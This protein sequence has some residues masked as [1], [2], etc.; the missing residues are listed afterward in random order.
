MHCL[1]L[2]TEKFM[3]I[4]AVPILVCY[5]VITT[6]SLLISSLTGSYSI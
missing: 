4:R 2:E 1:I 6:P 3:A 5:S